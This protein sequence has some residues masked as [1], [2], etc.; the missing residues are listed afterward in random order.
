MKKKLLMGLLQQR[1]FAMF[2]KLLLQ[3][4]ETLLQTDS[5]DEARFF[6]KAPVQWLS[7]YLDNISP[8]PKAE[9]VLML[10]RCKKLF[11]QSCYNWGIF[12]ENMTYA[13]Q[14]CSI[15]L[16]IIIIKNLR[17][18]PT[19]NAEIAMLN[20]NNIQLFCLWLS[21][22][23]E[24]SEDAERMLEERTDLQTFKT[25]YINWHYLKH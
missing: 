18:K 13:I 22:F 16:C 10:K 4:T 11:E 21:K 17:T 3:G 6:A 5:N 7:L 9:R 15:K 19:A 14:E 25:M 23:D 20:R 2:K 24:L 12:D 1:D 8:S